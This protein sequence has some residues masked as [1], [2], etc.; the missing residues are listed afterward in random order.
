MSFYGVSKLSE[1][2]AKQTPVEKNARIMKNMLR[3]Y[4]FKGH[5]QL[6]SDSS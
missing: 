4:G 2:D 6:S 3:E 1:P 5:T